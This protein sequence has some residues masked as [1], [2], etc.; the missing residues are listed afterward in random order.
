MELTKTRRFCVWS[1]QQDPVSVLRCAGVVV[2]PYID[3]SDEAL[4]ALTPLVRHLQHAYDVD[5]DSFNNVDFEDWGIVRL[6][7]IGNGKHNIHFDGYNSPQHLA[8]ARM[9]KEAGIDSLL[10]TYQGK[11]T[12]L[13]ETGLSMTCP[14]N[15]VQHGEGMELHSDGPR[16]ENTVLMSFEDVSAEMGALRTVP[17]S[18]AA[19]IDGLGHGLIDPNLPCQALCYKARCPVVIDGESLLK[20]KTLFSVLDN[21][22][23]YK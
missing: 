1:F 22:R 19:Y 4:A 15:G 12:Q 21:T 7:R 11:D 5:D 18:H 3:Q 8:L 17:G 14:S 10:S 13:R 6:P 20:E 23:T 2:L 9:A 16:G